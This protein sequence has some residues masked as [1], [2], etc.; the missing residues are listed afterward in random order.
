MNGKFNQSKY[1]SL[2]LRTFYCQFKARAT[3][4]LKS[5]LEERATQ[6]IGKSAIGL[7]LV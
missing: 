1:S 7:R 3:I 5:V 4:I 6:K 2:P